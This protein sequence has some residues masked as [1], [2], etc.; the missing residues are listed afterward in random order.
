MLVSVRPHTPPAPDLR[1]DAARKVLRLCRLLLDDPDEAEDARQDVLTKLF[2]RGA[3]DLASP[4]LDRWLARV[5][6]NA[7][8]DR[9]R[10][11]WWRWWRMRGRDVDGLVL[12][13]DDPTPE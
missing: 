12:T 2:A 10:S 6:V 8:R 3:V 13:A 1:G 9:R 11:G 7:C 5:T 4:F